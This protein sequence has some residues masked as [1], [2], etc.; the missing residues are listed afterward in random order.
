MPTGLARLCSTASE[1]GRIQ[2]CVLPPDVSTGVDRTPDALLRVAQAVSV[3]PKSP[4]RRE[5]LSR[6]CDVRTSLT[7]APPA[8]VRVG[9]AVERR[10][11][12]R[13][14]GE[15]LR[16]GADALQSMLAFRRISGPYGNE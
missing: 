16:V 4:R 14:T 5:L 15:N 10:D 2:V 13:F 7:D 3:D 9:I 1:V 11:G 6:A 12:S 8:D